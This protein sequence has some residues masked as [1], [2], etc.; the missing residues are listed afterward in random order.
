[1]A[2]S[3]NDGL[4]CSYLVTSKYFPSLEESVDK[5]VLV[6]GAVYYSH[7]LIALYAEKPTCVIGSDAGRS[8]RIDRSPSA[9]GFG[10]LDLEMMI[11]MV[12]ISRELQS[13]G[14]RWEAIGLHQQDFDNI[15]V[16]VSMERG[17]PSEAADDAL[18]SRTMELMTIE[19]ALKKISSCR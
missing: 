13:E 6:S 7:G 12:A 16:M 1:M 8:F 10:P 5:L 11:R 14:A 15:P 3:S 17:T 2:A 4:W 9:G 18:R 19:S